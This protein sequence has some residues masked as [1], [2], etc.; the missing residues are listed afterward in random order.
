MKKLLITA[1]LLSAGTVISQEFDWQWAKRGGGM[2]MAH[3]EFSNGFSQYYEHIKDIQVD[4]DNNYYFL[5]QVTASNVNYDGVPISVYNYDGASSGYSDVLLL[6]TTCDGTYRWSQVIGGGNIDAGHSISLDENGGVY[7]SVSVFADLNQGSINFIPPHFSEDDSLPALP[8]NV[9]P[10]EDHPGHKRL[11]I[12]KYSQDDGSL[13]WKKLLQGDVN[14]NTARGTISSLYVEGDGTIHALA[15]FQAGTHLDGN[16]IV[17][18]EYDYLGSEAVTYLKYYIVRLNGNG[19]YESV[20][21]VSID[22]VVTEDLLKFRYDPE[23]Q[24]YYIGGSRNETIFNDWMLNFGYNGNPFSK[25]MVFLALSYEGEELWR[26]EFAMSP[27]DIE[28]DVMRDIQIDDDSNIYICGRYLRMQNTEGTDFEYTWG[29]HSIPSM[30]GWG[31]KK[32]IMKMNSD[33]DVLWYQ[34]NTG[35]T[36]SEAQTGLP[37]A[38]SIGIG[39]NEILLGAEAEDEVWSGFEMTRP[40]NYMT[41]PLIVKLDRQTGEVIGTHDIWGTVNY[42]GDNVTAIKK[43]NDGNYIVG[44]FF[45]AELFVDANDGIETITTASGLSGYTDFFIAKLG[46]TPCGTPVAGARSFDKQQLKIYPNPASGIINIDTALSLDNYKVINI[47]GQVLMTGNFNGE[48]SIDLSSL[49][50]GAY[51]VKITDRSGASISK[52]IVKQ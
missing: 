30:S 46:A 4:Q 16:A 25:E 39:D 38:R 13:V 11:A 33:G 9:N 50:D 28:S 52:K 14:F 27:Q 12:A 2:R 40:T 48:S 5:A 49:A 31:H 10:S 32:F 21:P 26:K 47:M 8:E 42:R 24:R 35:Y 15:G 37:E 6:S 18:D 51:I 17:P 19:E 7:V 23:I 36:S 22:G 3:D 43:D 1:L 41:D 29:D 44:G 34:S 20:M 45:R